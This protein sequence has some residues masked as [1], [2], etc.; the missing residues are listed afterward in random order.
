LWVITDC[1][2][3]ILSIIRDDLRNENTDYCAAISP[4]EHLVIALRQEICSLYY[5][6]CGLTC[7]TGRNQ[8]LE[9]NWQMSGGNVVVQEWMLS[10][11]WQ[12][13]QWIR[14]DCF[15]ASVTAL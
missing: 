10:L 5:N 14:D 2:D 9:M 3:E 15:P 11:R 12:N 13:R 7:I 8:H 6:Y 4:G 1:C